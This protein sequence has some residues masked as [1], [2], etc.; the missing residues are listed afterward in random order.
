M[1]IS[2]NE[3]RRRRGWRRNLAII[4]GVGFKHICHKRIN[5]ITDLI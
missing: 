2:W 4:A 3:L 1:Q 5:L